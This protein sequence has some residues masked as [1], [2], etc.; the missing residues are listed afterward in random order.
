MPQD[1]CSPKS[2]GSAPR[3][4]K[5]KGAWKLA[6]TV[7]LLVTVTVCGALVDPTAT[8]PKSRDGGD[9]AKMMLPLPLAVPLNASLCGV[10]GA[11]SLM[12]TVPCLVPGAEV[13][14]NITF[15]VQEAPAARVRGQLQVRA[16]SPVEPILVIFN[17]AS[18][19]LV[20]VACWGELKVPT[21]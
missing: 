4:V 7:P 8:L 18:P 9:S 10:P 13:G 3:R 20:S 14:K 12:V 2:F 17:A 19:V 5:P 21:G 15:R 6:A 16:K 1:G 11:L